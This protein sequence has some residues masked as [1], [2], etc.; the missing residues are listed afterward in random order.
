MGCRDELLSYCPDAYLP[1][2]EYED[3]FDSL[4]DLYMAFENPI[5]IE[6]LLK[7]LRPLTEAE[8]ARYMA[9]SNALTQHYDIRGYGARNAAIFN[10]DVCVNLRLIVGEEFRQMLGAMHQVYV[11]LVRGR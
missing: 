6:F 10:H 3:G 9:V 2:Q 4:L 8:N 7:R 1:G 11:K 5:W